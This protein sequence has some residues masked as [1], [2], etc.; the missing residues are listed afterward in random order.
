MSSYIT[1]FKSPNYNDRAVGTNVEFL[2]MH[3]TG[4]DL[5]T[6]LRTLTDGNSIYPTSSHYVIDEEGDIY[7]LVDEMYRAWHAGASRW[8]DLEDINSRS[9]GIE[10]VH[11][12]YGPHYK[13]FSSRQMK[14]LITLSHEIL[15]RHSI[16]PQH[17]LGH[18]DIAPL[19]KVDPGPLFDW[20]KLAH[21]G[22]GFYPEFKETI[23]LKDTDVKSSLNLLKNDKSED[24]N[25][26]LQ[27]QQQLAIYGYPLEITGEVTEETE[28]VIRAFQMHFWPQCLDGKPSL[29]LK[30]RL[31]LLNQASHATDY[32]ISHFKKAL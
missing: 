3:Y 27:I 4:C 25:L 26:I 30:K 10:L 24:Q 20:Q 22:I 23:H 16:P 9:I 19:R 18:S 21:E 28:T 13:N 29:D 12:E 11:P 6:S 17:V 14:S 15:A 2:I 31:E 5:I 8:H 1:H 32:K 7:L